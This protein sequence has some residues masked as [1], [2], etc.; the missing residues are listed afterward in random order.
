M[1]EST[2]ILP[3]APVEQSPPSNI[4]AEAEASTTTSNGS[5]IRRK[6][7]QLLADVL[8]AEELIAG[9][10]SRN[11]GRKLTEDRDPWTHNAW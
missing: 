6:Q 2:P 5:R 11:G 4:P 1:T 7:P 3:P 8:V 10:P 9:A